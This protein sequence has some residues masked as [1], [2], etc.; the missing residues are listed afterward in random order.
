MTASSSN[1]PRSSAMRRRRIAFIRNGKMVFL[2]HVRT[3]L[4]ITLFRRGHLALQ[5]RGHFIQ[6]YTGDRMYYVEP[7]KP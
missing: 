6:A 1:L 7:R 4:G 2:Y 5:W 3:G